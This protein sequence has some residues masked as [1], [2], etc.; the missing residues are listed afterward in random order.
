VALTAIQD[1][2]EAVK[3]LRRAVAELKFV[4][5]AAPPISASK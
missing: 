2:V 5:V 3:E 4:A 1:P